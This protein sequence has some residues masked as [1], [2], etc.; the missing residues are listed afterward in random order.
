MINGKFEFNGLATAIGS[1]PHVDPHEACSQVLTH[2]PEIPAW[3]QLPQRSFLENMYVQYS[4]GFPGVKLEDKRIWVDRSQ[5]LSKTLEQLYSDYLDD[6]SNNRA[7]SHEYAAGLHIFI[8][9]AK[10]EGIKAVKGQVTGPFSFGLTVADQ[11][12]RPVLYDEILA[13]ALAKHLR[14]KA[15]WMEKL[16]SAI[17]PNTIIFIDEPYLSSL[18]SAFVSIPREQV[19]ALLEETLGGINGLKAIHCCGNTDWSLILQTSIDILSFDAYS[20]GES[21]SLYPSEVK[22]FLERG[23]VIA[24][25]IVPNE[26]PVL[27]GESESSLLDNLEDKMGLLAKKGIDPDL[28]RSRCLI[29][30]S[31]SLAS[32]SAD[33]AGKALELTAAVSAGFRQIYSLRN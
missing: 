9:T 30:P 4:E 21:L 7:I 11:D 2:L 26:E 31:C 17:S 20:Y 14:L 19:I 27:P 24:W 3:P 33:E 1:M 29:T 18:G 6:N 12:Q 22:E 13:D 28:I 32:L 15:T 23:G 16:L 25:G 5:D 10:K 8:N